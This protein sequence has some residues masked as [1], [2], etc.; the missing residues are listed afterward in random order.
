M[1]RFPLWTWRFWGALTVLLLL[2]LWRGL[3]REP[4]RL[5]VGVHT[6]RPDPETIAQAA[7][8]G[9]DA[10]AL[11]FPWRELEPTPGQFFWQDADESVAAADYF[12]LDLYVRLDQPPDWAL[13]KDAS[14][15]QP[16]VDVDAYR[17]FV[18][19]VAARYRGRVAGYVIWNEP[20]LALE[21]SGLAPDPAGYV[22]L[23][24]AGYAG[25]TGADPQATVISAGLAPTNTMNEEAMDERRFLEEMYRHGAGAYFHAL[26]A[27]AYGF[28]RAPSQPY[29]QASSPEGPLDGLVFQRVT[30]LRQLMEAHGDGEKPVY[31]TE[32]GWTVEP[33]AH[34]RWQKVTP[35]EQAVYLMEALDLAQARWP[36]LQLAVIWNLGGE[37]DPAWRGY[38]LLASGGSPR[39]AYHV[40]QE[41]LPD[42]FPPTPDPLPDRYTLVAPDVIIHLGDKRLAEPWVPLYRGQEPSPVWQGVFFV[43]EHE[44]LQEW[45][46]TLQVM[47]SNYW[48]NRIWLNGQALEPPIPVD[49]FSRTWVTHTWSVPAAFLRPGLNRLTITASRA[50]PLIQDRR[51]TYDEIQFRDVV[52]WR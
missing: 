14:T 3:D 49:D 44:D 13:R 52:L 12:G 34:S 39:P 10:V 35:E 33:V 2:I 18:A 45:R 5:R 4:A 31:I 47:Q 43:Y 46:L 48:S 32:M 51:F 38:S 30:A 7:A 50:L 40:L 27:H 8:L 1:R 6:I 21:W 20:N 37:V 24:M 9:V 11:L 23:L 19:A 15:G 29:T 25:V 26:G 16:P 42:R 28:G 41:R 17:R 36:W 22:A